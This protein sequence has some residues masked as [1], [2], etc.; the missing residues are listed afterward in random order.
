VLA[1]LCE[2]AGAGLDADSPPALT[3]KVAEAVP[4]Y[5]GLTLDEIGGNGI[6]WQERG[7]A[8]SLPTAQPSEDPLESPPELPEGLRLG[9]RPSLWAGREI[10]H[11]PSLRF[12]A[13]R[14]RAELSPSDAQR[15][16]IA[17]GDEVVVSVNGTSV[18]A[19]AAVRSS[20]NAGD[21]FLVGDRLPGGRVEVTKA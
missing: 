2:R 15:L 19:P 20:V 3:N 6:R 16:G 21:V 7:T 9:V 8:S 12:L 14:P 1:D 5:G 4:F 17:P 10:E 11:S 18:R 13:G